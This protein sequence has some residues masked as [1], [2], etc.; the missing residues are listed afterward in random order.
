MI[1]DSLGL[2]VPKE[3]EIKEENVTR[4]GEISLRF[5]ENNVDKPL[6]VDYLHIIPGSLGYDLG[7]GLFKH[8]KQ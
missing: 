7:A 2:L 5:I 6:P 3:F 4:E 1:A 8:R